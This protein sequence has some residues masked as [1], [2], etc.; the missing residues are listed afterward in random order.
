MD[1][2]IKVLE[3][4]K[5]AFVAYTRDNKLPYTH[6]KQWE[7]DTVDLAEALAELQ[8]YKAKIDEIAT[9]LQDISQYL[10]DEVHPRCEYDI[11]SRLEDLN[12]AVLQKLEE[13]DK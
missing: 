8:A 3:R 2:A 5:K 12:G 1:K 13:L 10:K 7:S 9:D 4:F 11:Y 6:K